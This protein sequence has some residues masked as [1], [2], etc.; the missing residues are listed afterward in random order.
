MT[1]TN[2]DGS[3]AAAAGGCNSSNP[4]SFAPTNLDVDNWVTSFKAL[5]VSSA[6][7]TAK[8]GCGFLAWQTN[9]ESR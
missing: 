2:D 1:P 5:G 3:R 4:A 9:G 7:L 6:V 8:H